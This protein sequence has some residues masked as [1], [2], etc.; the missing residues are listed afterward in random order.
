MSSIYLNDLHNTLIFFFFLMIRRPPRSTRTDTLFPYTTLFRSH[1]GHGDIEEV[2]GAA[3]GIENLGLRQARMQGL[4]MGLGLIGL[5][6]IDQR[7]SGP[8]HPV[9]IRAQ[10]LHDG[11]S[12]QPLDIRAPLV[13]RSHLPTPPGVPRPF[14]DGAANTPTHPGPDLPPPL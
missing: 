7:C 12:V 13:M 11:P 4:D 5:T 10:W 8:A 9:P 6:F 2:A 1:A 3:G 14:H